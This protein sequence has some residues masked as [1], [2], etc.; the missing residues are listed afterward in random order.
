MLRGLVVSPDN[1]TTWHTNHAAETLYA[2]SSS[3]ENTLDYWAG[4]AVNP[5]DAQRL[6][7]L[8]KRLEFRLRCSRKLVVFRGWV[9]TT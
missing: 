3:R 5:D 9:R 2:P 1:P 7:P 8:I 4:Y 6:Q